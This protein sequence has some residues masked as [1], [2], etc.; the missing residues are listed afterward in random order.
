[1]RQ[2][3]PDLLNTSGACDRPS[4]GY[5]DPPSVPGILDMPRTEAVHR[6]PFLQ[7][8]GIPS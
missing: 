7:G 6:Y 5:E 8:Y 1:M 2:Q 4:W 3:L